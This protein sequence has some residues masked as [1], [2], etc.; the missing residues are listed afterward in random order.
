MK[1]PSDP[2]FER[3]KRDF[4]FIPLDQLEKWDWPSDKKT[5]PCNF[6]VTRVA[7]VLTWAKEHLLVGSFG[8][9]DYREL[10]ELVVCYP[11]GGG[12]GGGVPWSGRATT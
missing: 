1:G 10:C 11:G 3:F 9:D 12:G 5:R 8:R 6:L 4:A 2:L 7:E